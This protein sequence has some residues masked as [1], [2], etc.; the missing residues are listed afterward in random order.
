MK[1]DFRKFDNLIC[2]CAIVLQLCSENE[3]SL[4]D[5]ELLP[6]IPRSYHPFPE[7]LV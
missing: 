4:P 1:T 5:N 6:A 3:H 7:R 2:R